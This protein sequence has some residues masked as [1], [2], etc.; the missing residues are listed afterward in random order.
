MRFHV[1]MTARAEADVDSALDSLVRYS[2]RAAVRWLDEL[3]KQIEELEQHADRYALAA[4]AHRLET[5][6]REVLFGKKPHVHRILYIIEDKVVQVLH[7][8]HAA[9]DWLKPGNE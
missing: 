2:R 5:E 7:I 8:R 1:K 6:L 3:L 9:R 4:E